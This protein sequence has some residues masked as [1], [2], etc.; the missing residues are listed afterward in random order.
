M[1]NGAEHVQE[2]HDIKEEDIT[3]EMKQKIK[4]LIRTS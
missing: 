2:V 4:G 1:K 3:T